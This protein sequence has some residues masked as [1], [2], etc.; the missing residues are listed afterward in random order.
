MG[1]WYE[2]LDPGSTFESEARLVEQSDI[3][4]FVRLSG[5]DNRLHTDDDFARSNGFERRIAHGALVVSIATGLAWKTGILT[6]TTLAFRAIE[7][8]KFTLPV[9]PGDTVRLRGK[10]GATKAL[11]RLKAGLV[12]FELELLNQRDALVSS[13]SLNMLMRMRSE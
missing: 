4:T 13:G 1:R 3:D 6:D 11:P 8:W 5:D 2:E 10:I 7:E 12:R 9:Y